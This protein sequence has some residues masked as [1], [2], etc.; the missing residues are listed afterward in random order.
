[1]RDLFCSLAVLPLFTSKITRM[2]SQGVRKKRREGLTHL[3]FCIKLYEIQIESGRFFLH[4]HPHNAWSWRLPEM[5]SLAKVNGHVCRQG[6]FL[7][8]KQGLAP[9]AE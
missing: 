3:M 1:M 2:R 5:V 9:A 7:R 6:M 8:D 4:G